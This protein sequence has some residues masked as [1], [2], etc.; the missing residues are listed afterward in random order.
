MTPTT[1]CTI[2]VV[3]PTHKVVAIPMCFCWITRIPGDST[4]V[5]NKCMLMNVVNTPEISC[6]LPKTTR[7]AVEN[8][9]PPFVARTKTKTAAKTSPNH[10]ALWNNTP[11]RTMPITT[12]AV[13]RT[14]S[15]LTAIPPTVVISVLIFSKSILRDLSIQN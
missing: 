9:L 15:C 12:F 8:T 4:V 1:N 6:P 14:L 2:L 7:T 11:T 13:Y 5:N 3:N 10:A